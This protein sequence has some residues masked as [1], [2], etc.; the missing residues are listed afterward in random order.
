[1]EASP[2]K[3]GDPSASDNLYM[4]KMHYSEKGIGGYSFWP[5]QGW[6]GM[7]TD[8]RD[9]VVENG[10]EGRLN[11][12]ASRV[13][14]EDG[15]LLGLAVADPHVLPNEIFEETIIETDCLI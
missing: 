15:K 1:L 7:F 5:G 3:W 13:V 9:A 8:L 2:E 12:R 6:D 11:T 4:R 10:G 14:I